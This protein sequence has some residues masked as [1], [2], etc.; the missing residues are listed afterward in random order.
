MVNQKCDLILFCF[1]FSYLQLQPPVKLLIYPSIAVFYYFDL[2]NILYFNWISHSM[3]FICLFVCLFFT[4]YLPVNIREW[5]E[6]DWEIEGL[7][8]SICEHWK[9]TI[10]ES[11][12]LYHIIQ[13]KITKFPCSIVW[14]MLWCGQKYLSILWQALR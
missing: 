14:K 13:K 1:L 2:F 4:S 11:T 5:K 10:L 12:F 9:A 8:Y 6:I 7:P 3:F